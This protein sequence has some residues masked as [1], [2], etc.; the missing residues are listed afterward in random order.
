MLDVRRAGWIDRKP[1]KIEGPT[2]LGQANSPSS[3]PLR[4]A[5]RAS[6]EIAALS[7]A[8]ARRCAP[9]A[10]RAV[11]PLRLMLFVGTPCPCPADGGLL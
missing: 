3:P 8:A 5:P 6:P 7:R 1:K 10:L 2:T 11:G 4:S 9:C